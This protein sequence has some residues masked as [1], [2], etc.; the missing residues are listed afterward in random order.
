MLTFCDQ[1]FECCRLDFDLLFVSE[2]S[3]NDGTPKK[4]DE[5]GNSISKQGTS[6]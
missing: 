5:K 1:Q 4:P 6:L 2:V 3:P